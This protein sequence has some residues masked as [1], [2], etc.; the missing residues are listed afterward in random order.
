MLAVARRLMLRE[1]PN[2][3]SPHRASEAGLISAVGI[4]RLAVPRVTMT[5]V[6]SGPN[7]VTLR[8]QPRVL[9]GLSLKGT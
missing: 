4:K 8:V 3:V 6:A 9:S 5:C 7:P 2:E 1:Y